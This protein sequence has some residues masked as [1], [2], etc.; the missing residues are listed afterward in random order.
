[1]VTVT[2]SAELEE[3]VMEEAAQ[4]GTT[5]ELLTLDVLQGR[6][7]KPS[8]TKQMAEGATL[9]DALADYIGAIDIRDSS[10]PKPAH[11]SQEETDLFQKINQGLPESIWREY[12]G[13]IAKR[14]AENLTQEEHARLIDLSDRIEQAHAERMTNLV[15]LSRQRQIPLK[16]L[17]EQLGIRPRKV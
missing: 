16:A 11:L 10:P 12:H 4:K 15:E 3:A 1:M 7:L 9:A 17:M 13:L 6:F 2:L 14:R 8:A 5:A